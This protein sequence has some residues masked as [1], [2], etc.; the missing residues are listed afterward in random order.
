MSA[1][2]AHGASSTDVT[3]S[4]PPGPFRA[5]LSLWRA[6]VGLV[7]VA[8]IVGIA[9]VGPYVAPYGPQEAVG[10]GTPFVRDVPGSLFG[11]GYLGQDVWSRFLHG[12]RSVL[13]MAAIATA[14]ALLIGGFLGLAA[15]YGKGRVDNVIMRSLDILISFPSL[16]LAMVTFTTLGVSV[17]LIVIVVAVTTTPRIAR[18]VRGAALPVVERD[19]IGAAEALG[20]SRTFIIRKELL[21]NVAAPLLVEATLRLAYSIGL[22]AS[23]GFL[24]FTPELNAAN[25]GMMVQE[26]RTSME[27]QPWG[28]VVPVVAIALLTVGAGL[29]SDGISRAAAGIDRKRA[30]V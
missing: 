17:P 16:L 22:I 15:A 11:S 9:L 4:R 13:L 10:D 28:V 21:P 25:W 24:G 1:V 18:V 8:A 3:F 5:S 6:R 23:L 14:L 20:E 27:L 12:G 26:N 30:E 2:A 7:L 19:F 29:L